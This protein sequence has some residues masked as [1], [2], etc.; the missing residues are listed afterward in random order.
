[1]ASVRNLDL[2]PVVARTQG[3]DGG[4]NLRDA[5]SQLASNELRKS[6][7]GTLD[8]RGGW[9]KRLGC[10]SKGT[11]D[12]GTD[13]VLSVYTFYRGATAPQVLIHTTAGKVY[14]TNDPTA[15][16]IVWTQVTTGLSTTAPMSWETFNS[17]V[18]FSNGVD[19][20]ASW[21]GTTYT[22]YPSAPKGKYLRLWKDT[23]W[24][25]G[26]PSLVD[27][28]YSSTAGDAETWPAPSWVDI[29]KGDGD[30][31]NALGSDGLVLIVGKRNR[32]MTIYD[33]VTFANRVVD[34]EKG[35][36]SH[37]SVIQHEGEIYYLTRRGIA[38]FDS[39]GPA[40]IISAKLD[41][42]FD[43][44]VL[45]LAQLS[46]AWAYTFGNQVGWALPE[47][48]SSVPTLQIEYYPRLGPISQF[49]TIGIGPWVFHRM[50]A[51]AFTRFRSGAVEYLFGAHNASNKF[52]HLFAPVGTDDG[53][54]FTAIMETGPYEFGA[55]TR[56]KY[57]RR[58]RFLGRGQ[59]TA[60]LIR[61]FQT[62]VYKTRALD[63]S[64]TTD[65]WALSDLWG[66]GTWGP[67]AVFKEALWNSD[68]YGR[69]FQIR[70]S[71]SSTGTSRNLIEVG[72]VEYALTAGEWAVFMIALEGELLG[73]RDG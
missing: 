46:K 40:R 12:A 51:Q 41:R 70:L 69:Y 56:T 3:F 10:I 68:A 11:F 30:T 73:L 57:V 16:P 55:P 17:K 63:M 42:L 6:E 19:N 15:N 45:N 36:E 5:I 4:V 2:Q 14:Y 72:S 35:I 60:Q 20:Y 66:V 27:R 29:T 13:R 49:G 37:F 7:N 34:F 28:V 62:A 43:P 64:A 67:D 25:S 8:E 38:K 53:A 39:S 9:S 33:P 23:M 44:S 52:L 22:T 65:L 48:G 61:N 47:T 1:M 71:D 59:V 21:D 50:P 26:I 18:Y 54:T 58:I 24:M 31:V 32:G